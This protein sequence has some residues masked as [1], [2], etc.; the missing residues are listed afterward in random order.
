[1]LF[2]KRLGLGL[3]FTSIC[4]VSSQGED[5]TY[6]LQTPYHTEE[7]WIVSSVCRNAFELLSYM[8]DKKGE[9]V[10]PENVSI[11]KGSA[12]ATTYDV[13]LHGAHVTVQATLHWPGSIWASA[14]YVPFCQAAMDQLKLVKSVQK[15]EEKG[16]PLQSL[17]D[18]SEQTIEMENQR[19]SL[20]LNQEPDNP[21][22]QEQAALILGTLAMKDNS[23]WFWDPR[24]ICNHVSAHLAV[25]RCLEENPSEE[26]LLA[27]CLVGLIADTKKECSQELN[28]LDKLSAD[29]KELIPWVQ[30]GRMRNSRDWRLL[31]KPKGASG[32]EQVEYFRALCEAVDSDRAIL[33]L[34]TDSIQNRPDWAR[35]VLQA[36]FSVQAGHAFS[37]QA[38][39]GEIRL[40]HG[41]FPDRFKDNEIISN[42][43]EAPEDVLISSASDSK[44]LQVIS[45]GMWAS[46]FQRHLCHAIAETGNFLET[47]WGVPEQTVQLD[48]EVDKTFSVLRLFP[49]LQIVNAKLRHGKEDPTAVLETFRQHPEWAADF[50]FELEPSPNVD[51]SKFHQMVNGWFSP[52]FPSGTAFAA[53]SRFYN[54]AGSWENRP[55]MLQKLYSIAPLQFKVAEL[56]LYSQ[57][58]K[59]PTYVQVQE[60]MGPMTAYYLPANNLAKRATGI[61]EDKHLALYKQAAEMNPN[62]YD[63]LAWV[64]LHSGH[65]KE[66]AEAYQNWFDKGTD[67]VLVSNGCDWLVD[68]YYDHD[69]K[70]KAL[71]I[72][73]D[74]AEVYSSRGL[75]TM[76][77]L[78]ERMGRLDEAEEYGKKIQERYNDSS[79]LIAFY[80]RQLDKGNASYKSKY[81]DTIRT[82]FPQGLKQ[83]TL[84]DFSGPPTGG[85]RFQATNAA[86]RS[87]GVSSDQVIVALDGYKVESVAQYTMTRG[88]SDSPNM[89]LIVWDGKTYQTLRVNQPGRLFGVGMQDYSP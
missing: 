89:Q 82:I 32:L 57:Y 49:Y 15:H 8:A 1:M 42:L 33:W 62:Q 29:H 50:V 76:A 48:Q 84:A 53:F 39:A 86:M 34:Q 17:L 69:Q 88:F 72:A 14:A 46:Y 28:D 87:N 74:A 9:V 78:M 47:K 40:M 67:R 52:P 77:H 30:A 20:W 64:L 12:D 11:K 4:T 68:Y 60:I 24:D 13:V 54:V 25:A 41:L 56:Q 3:V 26:G 7:E 18:Y 2:F 63:D 58:S 59:N 81:D 73:K 43:N 55:D 23:G 51:I 6:S 10:P 22:A 61:D 5:K 70:D 71:A 65:E 75:A 37:T 27:E 45:S 21:L 38:I 44:N 19:V 31:D 83:V 85:M 36:D 66:A 16:T 79:N 35:M 80:K